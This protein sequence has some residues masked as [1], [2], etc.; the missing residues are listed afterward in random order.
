[1]TTRHDTIRAIVGTL[2]DGR[3]YPNNFP[4]ERTAPTWPAIRGTIISRDNELDQCGAGTD[5]DDD[6]RVQLDIVASTYDAL[7]ALRI[8]VWDAMSA[9]DPPW[10]RQPGS[11]ETWDSEARVHRVSTDF[12]L[13]QSTPD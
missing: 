9:A 5:D 11:F 7:D 3:Y 1:M 8:S 12:I 4:Q 6:V 13:H 2:V 10:I